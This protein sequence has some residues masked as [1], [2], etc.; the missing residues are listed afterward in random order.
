MA[1]Q[2]M[3]VRTY[4]FETDQ[5]TVDLLTRTVHGFEPAY[6]GWTPNVTPNKRSGLVEEAITLRVNSTSTDAIATSLQR[7]ADAAR[8]NDNYHSGGVE[9]Y[10]VWFR[11]QQYGETKGR[12]S[13]VYEVRHEPASSVFD[14]SLR[15]SYH[16]NKYTVGITRAPWWEG[17]AA[18]TITAS[19]VSM[20][21]GTFS[22]GTIYGDINARIAK[23]EVNGGNG[24]LWPYGQFW[25][26]FRSTRYSSTPTAWQPW[27]FSTYKATG[28]LTADTYAMGGT[29][30]RYTHTYGGTTF[31]DNELITNV[32]M[33]SV[34][35]GTPA[36]MYGNFLVLAR[37]KVKYDSTADWTLGSSEANFLMHMHTYYSGDSDEGVSARSYPRVA[38]GKSNS[39]TA[40]TS[41]TADTYRFYELGEVQFPPPGKSLGIN[42]SNFEIEIQADPP[43]MTGLA[44]TATLCFNGLA[45]IPTEGLYWGGRDE[46]VYTGVT[47]AKY[48]GS[49]A[50]YG[51]NGPDDKNSALVAGT[52]TATSIYGIQEPN[53][54]DGIPIGTGIAVFAAAPLTDQVTAGTAWKANIVL[55]TVERW[56]S[57]RGNE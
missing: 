43:D 29:S 3:L 18:G 49:V 36:H 1:E 25:L 41:E 31:T 35:A 24:T 48:G 53:Y 23:L 45:F 13:L 9:N 14:A 55:R 5:G 52:S 56:Q 26:G 38:V 37:A 12:Q 28:S 20:Y 32:R 7:L 10:A 50:Y 40:G 39:T 51:F 27:Y 33:G 22:F 57:L 6:Q 30:I 21:G 4:D 54:R 42:W 44:G 46:P 19:S 47:P 8:W 34:T 11:V 16:W 2:L 17:T 15:T